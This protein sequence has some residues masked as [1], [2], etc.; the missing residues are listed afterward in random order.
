[1]T[2]HLRP[3]H[4]Y[5]W[6][7]CAAAPTFEERSP[8]EQPNDAAREG[9]CAAWVAECVLKGDAHSCEDL[10][11]RTHKNGWLVTFD[12]VQHV[13]SYVDLIRSFGGTTTVEQEGRL[14]AFIA[15]T[16]DASTA[17]SPAEPWLLRVVDLKYGYRIVDVFELPQLILYGAMEILRLQNPG[18]THVELAIYQP[19]AFH[20]DGTYR[21]WRVTVPE[22]WQHMTRLVEAGQ[23]CQSPAPIATPGKHCG[24]CRAAASCVALAH[25]NYAGFAVVEDT[26]QRMMTPQELA[27]ELDYLRLMEQ[28]LEARKSAIEAEASAR[29]G[30]EH[31]PGY[32][33]MER[34]GQRRFKFPPDVIKGLTG[35]DAMS[36]PKA[37]TPAELER[38]GADVNLVAALSETPRIG[39]KLAK[40]PENHF[41]KAF[42]K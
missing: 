33:M 30:K 20:P 12:M 22:L 35:V 8:P 34:F 26:R 24:E 21:K 27:N 2:V 11:G 38:R 23:K 5:R 28:L 4:A 13:Q 36:E 29:I 6:S 15:G 9:T 37:V 18:I 32:G 1:M 10:L 39:F 16:L 31:I 40:L 7:N 17:L 14:N 41:R 19:R 3:S 42:A 25:S